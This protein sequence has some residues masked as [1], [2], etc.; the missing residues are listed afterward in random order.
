MSTCE[1][2]S[3]QLKLS[4][5]RVESAWSIAGCQKEEDIAYYTAKE[6]PDKDKQGPEMQG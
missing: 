3:N 1:L 5:K 2:G 6:P 4:L